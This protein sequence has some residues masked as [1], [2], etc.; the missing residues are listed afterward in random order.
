MGNSETKLEKQLRT[1]ETFIATDEVLAR[2]DFAFENLVLDGGGCK[3]V[4]FV[5]VIKVLENVGVFQNLKRFAGSSMGGLIACLLAV[6]HTPLDVV[7]IMGNNELEKVA[8]DHSCGYCS[9]IPNL[10]SHYGW[11]H[12]NKL[13]RYMGDKI[14]AKTGNRDITFKQLYD[15]Y[16]KELVITATNINDM[17]CVYCHVKTT[18]DMP[19]ALAVKM[20]MS[21]P[22]FYH[23]VTHMDDLYID[24]G[25]LALFPIYC[26]DGWWL[27][28]KPEDSF[29]LKLQ[30]L[31]EIHK[32]YDVKVRF[33]GG[34]NKKTLGGMMVSQ[35]E[36]ELYGNNIRGGNESARPDT[37]LARKR[38]KVEK[39]HGIEQNDQY[40]R[41][42]GAMNQLLKVLADSN[43][44]TDQA[45]DRDDFKIAL[46]EAINNGSFTAQHGKLLFGDQWDVNAVIDGL[47]FN[48]DGKI[49]YQELVQF[50]EAKGV[51]ILNRFTG[52]KRLPVHDIRDFITAVVE[53]LMLNC[54]RVY[55]D[56]S[57]M[58]RTIPVD[59]DYLHSFDFDMEP[60]DKI[61]GIEQGMKATRSFL[62]QYIERESPP[63][64]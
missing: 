8:I 53:T 47:D 43:I 17:Q 59:V 54:Q 9:L 45:I 4:G 12:G 29:L 52:D 25:I 44:Q 10:L 39:K 28:L 16:G 36:R 22:G 61:F 19:I 58:E 30:P 13:M 38:T 32:L 34:Q 46:T 62:R 27:S 51:H 31:D 55:F 3:C 26:F 21:F 18:P 1:N 20:T 60:S 42:S 7:K 6:G 5:G 56:E 33:G 57:D 11:N 63:L 23:A 49:T 2:Y 40:S 37:K 14:A 35:Y 50:A 41:L 48:R 64:K 15:N 24:G